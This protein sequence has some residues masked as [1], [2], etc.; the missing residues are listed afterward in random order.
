MSILKMIL[1]KMKFEPKM[2]GPNLR[3]FRHGN[4]QNFIAIVNDFGKLSPEPCFLMD[5]KDRFIQV[6]QHKQ[7]IGKSDG[8]WPCEYDLYTRLQ[9]INIPNLENKQAFEKM[10]KEFYL[11]GFDFKKI[12]LVKDT[13]YLVIPPSRD[14]FKGNIRNDFVFQKI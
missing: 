5:F 7:F 14:L 13:E 4:T 6:V 2:G 12:S 11:V 1:K 9:V 10:V 8:W 3:I